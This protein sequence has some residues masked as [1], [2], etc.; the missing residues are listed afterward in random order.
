MI[1]TL[2]WLF[3][4]GCATSE[5]STDTVWTKDH[6][7][8]AEQAEMRRL[9]REIARLD[10]KKIVREGSEKNFVAIRS[11]S[12][13]FTRRL[14]SRT[15][16]AHDE[17]YGIGRPLQRQLVEDGYSV[18]IYVSYGPSWYAWFMRRLAER[19]ANIGFFLRHLFG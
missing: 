10:T 17:L 14:D 7:D 9:A 4:C 12:A 6:S 16:L 19:P 5:R 2:S 11:D 15:F 8:R 18:R 3:L 13:V 1:A